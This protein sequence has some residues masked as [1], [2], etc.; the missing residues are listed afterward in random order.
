MNT[1]AV[2]PM[3]VAT[4][5]LMGLP[6]SWAAATAGTTA[7]RMAATGM[8]AERRRVMRA[9]SRRL[10]AGDRQ[11]Q[12]PRRV[13]PEHRVALARRQAEVLDELDRARLERR[14]RRRIAAIEH[15][16]G[17]DRIEHEARRRS[18]IGHAVE[19]HHL[20]I[21]AGRMLDFHRDIG[22]EEERL[23]LQLI[24]IVEPADHLADAAAAMGTDDRHPRKILQ[25]AAHDQPRQGK[26]EI[27][28]AA[29]AGSEAVLLH[30]LFAE[31]YMGRMDHHRD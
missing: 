20:Q 26:A 10:R 25:E 11:L 2:P 28:R 19:M 17:A 29:D 15:V 22:P 27:G 16:I 1:S 31:S 14:Q 24:G 3:P 7:T 12:Q 5:T 4:M 8:A 9:T 13:A 18:V 30:A 6:R 23:V 21:V